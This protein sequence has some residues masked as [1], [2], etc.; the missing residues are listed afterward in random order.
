M[1]VKDPQDSW[2]ESDLKWSLALFEETV[3][4]ISRQVSAKN[5]YMIITVLI[6]V[7]IG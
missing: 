4:Q 6:W 2:I 3:W 1:S 7:R 5:I